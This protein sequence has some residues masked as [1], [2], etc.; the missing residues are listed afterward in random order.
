MTET[1]RRGTRIV[2]PDGSEAE[3]PLL[4]AALREHGIPGHEVAV[5]YGAPADAA[6]WVERVGDAEFVIAGWG[7]PNEALEAFPNVRAIAF[8]G[9]GAAD[10]I[11]L[12]LA[13]RLGIE[14]R[15]VAGYGDDSVA[16]HALA[17]LL[18]A[19]RA[20]PQIDAAVR[21]GEWPPHSGVLL[22]GKTLGVIGLGGIGR[23]MAELGRGIGMEVIGW[24]RR[25]EQGETVDERTGIEIAP[26]AEVF[27]RADAVSLHLG[28]NPETAGL[29]SAELI[30]R[31]P[32]GA[33]L[34]NTARAGVM[35]TAAALAAAAAGRIRFAVDVF[36]AEPLAADS[37]ERHST[38]TVLTPHTAFDTPEA[39]AALYLGAIAQLRGAIDAAQ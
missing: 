25:A 15:T 35:D 36:D 7:I 28:F 11:D 16:E 8:L 12:P 21:R 34:V 38:G 3:R 32:H 19:A 1:Q 27:G 2:H 10:H 22:N 33:I 6:Q 37:P 14:V 20:I 30:E 5:H 26:L 31:L 29:I 18:A 4:D 24:T 13:E 17:L 9:T 23:R 39:S